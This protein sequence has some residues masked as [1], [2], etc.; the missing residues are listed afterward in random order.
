MNKLAGIVLTLTLM[1]AGSTFGLTSAEAKTATA[2]APVNTAA[3][4][5]TAI[6]KAAAATAPAPLPSTPV[7]PGADTKAYPKMG[8]GLPSEQQG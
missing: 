6:P 3:V 1:T 2:Q 8:Q 7:A 5:T 4:A